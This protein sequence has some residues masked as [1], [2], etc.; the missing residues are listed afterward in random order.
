[1]CQVRSNLSK[2]VIWHTGFW[3]F[4]TVSA[5]KLLLWIFLFV[6][7]IMAHRS[8]CSSLCLI[9]SH[10]GSFCGSLWL[11]WLNVTCWDSLCL[12]GSLLV[13]VVHWYFLAHFG[14]ACLILSS[15]FIL[16]L[17]ISLILTKII[18][19][20]TCCT[21]FCNIYFYFY[22]L[23]SFYKQKDFYERHALFLLFVCLFFFIRFV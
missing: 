6:V 3:S 9:M 12:T 20:S 2:K 14:S 21:N 16:S 7:L 1:M 23:V 15:Q 8:C 13:I 19:I 22:F 10:C 17:T 11:L 18:Y 5:Q 4:L